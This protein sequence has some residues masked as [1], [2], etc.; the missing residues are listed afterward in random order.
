L[1]GTPPYSDWVNRE[2]LANAARKKE[3][4]FTKLVVLGQVLTAPRGR[5]ELKTQN[6]P[7]LISSPTKRSRRKRIRGLG[8]RG[9]FKTGKRRLQSQNSGLVKRQK[10]K[11]RGGCKPRGIFGPVVNAAPNDEKGK[12]PN[13]ESRRQ[14]KRKK[15]KVAVIGASRYRQ[16]GG[17]AP[18]KPEAEDFCFKEG[19]E[20]R[21]GA[22]KESKLGGGKRCHA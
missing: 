2:F 6:L 20:K 3:R 1:G 9:G 17:R 15:I 16:R 14:K 11:R 4:C 12:A 19:V 8:K 7:S 21:V 18:E 10:K 5:Q 22:G 13:P